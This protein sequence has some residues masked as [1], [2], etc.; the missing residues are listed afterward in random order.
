MKFYP[1][2][3]FCTAF[4]LANFL[5]VNYSI[6]QKYSNEFLSI[7]VSA[8]A[9]GMGNSVVASIDDVTAGYW[10]PAGLASFG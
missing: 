9:Q 8:R 7:G 1:T 6:A 4:L 5:I 3:T 2:F 10:N